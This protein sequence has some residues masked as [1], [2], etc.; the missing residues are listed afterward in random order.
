MPSPR[1]F[2][3]SNILIY[4][5]DKGSPDKLSVAKKLVVVH[6]SGRSGVI[7]IQVLQEYFSIVTSKLKV[8]PAACREKVEILCNLNVF[9]PGFA[10]VLAAIDLH[11]LHRISFWDA[12]IVRAALQSG[13]KTLLS[14]D[15]Q[16]GRIIDGLQILN[17]FLS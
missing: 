9:Q 14:E 3:D 6:L 16:H 2:L 13:C 4:T 7:S 8:D 12:L 10:D 11:R 15:M 5:D 1:V 17:P